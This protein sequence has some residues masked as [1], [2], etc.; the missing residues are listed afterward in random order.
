M[1]TMTFVVEPD[2]H[3]G[4]VLVVSLPWLRPDNWILGET[5]SVRPALVERAIRQA[6]DVGWSPEAGHSRFAL[7]LTEDDVT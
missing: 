5:G 2:Q 1:S 3:P 6:L 7:V 4:R